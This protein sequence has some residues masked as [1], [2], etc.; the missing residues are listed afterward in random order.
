MRRNN[1]KKIRC[2]EKS[3]CS[4]DQGGVMRDSVASDMKFVYRYPYLTVGTIA[5]NY[6][7]GRCEEFNRSTTFRVK[8]KERIKEFRIVG[9][10]YD[11]YMQIKVNG[12]Q[13]YNGPK[14]GNKLVIKNKGWFGADVDTGKGVYGCELNT[15]WNFKVNI[16]L[17]PYLREG[18]NTID[19]KVIVSGK[20]EG[21]MDIIASQYCCNE[22]EDTNITE[23]KC[24]YV[25]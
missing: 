2:K 8:D 14:G 9:V 18:L 6:W 17:K 23:V 22:W 12:Q 19:V 3:E 11:D 24:E 10:G 13:V 4:G 16:D 21:W 5:D 20:G 7:S 25:N 15:D 1:Y